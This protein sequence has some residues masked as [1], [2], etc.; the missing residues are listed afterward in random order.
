MSKRHSGSGKYIS[1]EE[2]FAK[3]QTALWLS[4]LVGQVPMSEDFFECLQWA[5]DGLHG[6]VDELR[7]AVAANAFKGKKRMLLRYIDE[8]IDADDADISMECG[9]M[10]AKYPVAASLLQE[11]V[12]QRCEQVCDSKEK[13]APA[14]TALKHLHHLFGLSADAAAFCE[15]VYLQSTYSPIEEYFEDELQL[16]EPRNMELLARM[17]GRSVS[18]MRRVVDEVADLH[19]LCSDVHAGDYFRLQGNIKPVWSDIKPS[20]LQKLFCAP[21]EGETLPLKDFNVDSDALWQIRQLLQRKGDMPVHIMLYGVPGTGKTT[22]ARSIAEALGMDAFAVSSRSEDDEDDRRSS[23]VAGANMVAR[24]DNAFLVADE[25]EHLLATGGIFS[26]KSRDKAWLNAFLEHPGRRIIWIVN[27]IDHL[28]R[29]VLRRFT[30]SVQF[31]P[32]TQEQRARTFRKILARHHAEK[33]LSGEQVDMLVR[34]YDKASVAAFD[35]AVRQSRAITTG[36][37]HFYRS[38]NSM[39]EANV[40]L[41]QYGEKPRRIHA[42]D[43]YTLEGACIRDAAKLVEACRRADT[44]MRS[45][46]PVPAG[47]ATMLFYGPPGTG[48]TA[49]ARYIA[50]TIKRKCV[51]KKASD[52]L[53][54]Y[55]GQSEQAVA[56]AFREAEEDGKVL[57]IDEADSF[58]Y[59]RESARRSW[60]STL[61]NEFLTQLEEC[62]CFCICTTNR[63]ANMDAAAMRRFAHKVEFTYATPAQVQALYDKLL[64]PLCSEELPDNLRERLARMARLAPGDFHAVQGQ[65][66][67]L[68]GDPELVRHEDMVA[69]LENEVQKKLGGDSKPLGFRA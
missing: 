49:L 46:K 47:A 53:S 24:R 26:D 65:F 54:P 2:R 42:V 19:I 5:T 40:T 11:L 30:Y 64:A 18:A 61:V 69:A 17:F 36:S 66:G 32:L 20:Q 12:E 35:M 62:R 6:L 7:D 10:V 38:V 37:R 39:L 16:H 1:S 45:G 9:H 57:V 34:N 8:E 31:E 68:F 67:S 27:D 59:S 56:Q 33:Q 50:D 23:L 14:K 29:A 13:Y 55:I 25:A 51:V 41:T 52:L 4:R 21:V 28:H 48:K 60:E 44:F 43:D 22:F 15:F 58:I 3:R 63:R